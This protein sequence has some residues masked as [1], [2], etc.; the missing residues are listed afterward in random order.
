MEIIKMASGED[1][2]DIPPNINLF[3]HPERL[4]NYATCLICNKA[5]CKSDIVR[6][7]KSGKGFFVTNSLLVCSD[8]NITYNNRHISNIENEEYDKLK[9]LKLKIDFLNQE[10]NNKLQQSSES[11]N[12][13]T[14]SDTDRKSV[15]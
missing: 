14:T 13:N 2:R 10:Y 11:A 3:C 9:T 8:H 15:V 7:V 12:F 5:F 1:A 6:K 4:Y